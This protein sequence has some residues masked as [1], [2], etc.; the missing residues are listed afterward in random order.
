MTKNPETNLVSFKDTLNLPTTNFS[1]RSFAE[2]NDPIMITRWHDEK[3]SQQAQTINSGGEKFILHVGP[4]YAN[5]NIHL[6]HAYSW[7]LKD[8]VTKYHRMTGKHV[9][10]VP[11]WDCH[12]LPIEFQVSKEHPNASRIELKKEC[13]K[14]AQAW[15]N[16]Q[17]E[18]FER[19]GILMDWENPYITMDYAYEADTLRAFGQL[20]SKGYIK[21]KLKTVPWCISCETVLASAEIEYQDKK[22]PSLYVLFD[23]TKESARQLGAQC[24]DKQIS[25]VVWTTTPWTLPLN[26]AVLAKPDSEY[27][28]I[29]YND[30]LVIIGK[31][32]AESVCQLTDMDKRVVAE[33]NSIMLKDLRLHHPFEK[34]RIVPIIL[35][36]EVSTS[37]GTAFVHC[38]PGAGP[39]DYE[40]GIKNSIDIYSP[41][42]QSGNYTND[43]LPSELAGTPITDAHGFV[44]KTLTEH[45]KLFAKKSIAHSYPHCWRCHKPLIFRATK[46]WFCSLE[47]DKLKDRALDAIKKI[48]MIPE[49]TRNRF[50]STVQGRLEWCLSRQRVWG[51]PISALICNGCDYTHISKELV[52]QV[53]Q[54][55]Q[56]HGIEYWDSVAVTD[57]A[58]ADVHCPQCNAR[59]WRKEEDILDVWFDSGI[60]HYAVLKKREDQSYPA[61][62]YLEGKDQHRGWFQSSLLTSL[63][64][65]KDIPAMECILTHG[66]TVDQKGHKM[67]KSLG[68]VVSPDEMIKKL[69]TD[70]LRLWVSSIDYTNDAV[71][72]EAV[73]KNILIVYNKIRNT[74]RFL[75]ANLYDFN[76]ATDAVAVP[77]LL[78]IDQYALQELFEINTL[79]LD[80]YAQYDFTKVFH[81]LSDYCAVNLSAFYLD[82]IKDRLYVEKSDGLKRRSAQTACFYILDT[83]T[84]LMSPILS[85]TAEQVSDEYQK[86]KIESIH[87]QPFAE[88]PS[89]WQVQST[90]NKDM[91]TQFT[92]DNP[93][94]RSLHEMNKKMGEVQFLL[95]QQQSWDFIKQV[96]SEILKSIERQREKQVIKH[97]LEAKI[98]IYFDQSMQQAPVWNNF[99]TQCNDQNENIEEFL[100]EFIIVSQCKIASSNAANELE[101]TD[102]PGL[103]IKTEHADGSKCPRCWN[104]S[105][106]NHEHALCNRCEKIV[107]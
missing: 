88:I 34:N 51:T 38:A 63:V 50:S 40:I 84:R 13:R 71:V 16:R 39:V 73:V 58:G 12:G 87:L 44:I 5:G 33:F 77:E 52:E 65:D 67:S 85:F 22:D 53:A 81:V 76:I 61:D 24:A 57:L 23:V 79:L 80:A 96:R 49:S 36:N 104:W 10:V 29:E 17:M 15:V 20:V 2:I 54:Q 28:L 82:I 93:R 70:G 94:L 92:Q 103:Y 107:T 48:T 99:I 69:G 37:E 72:S 19:L 64:I 106:T 6:G 98:T 45:G 56:V 9:P 59:E 86:D 68:N 62:M 83:L 31:Q 42:S 55:V 102:I 46:Q 7:I 30:S 74:C 14:Y 1:I 90:K 32:L 8:M 35:D 26:R 21:R 91:Y 66:F 101:K 3:L 75:L 43:I 60:S 11:G 105:I 25:L 47:K 18:A 100:K 78:V 41:V 4:P 27:V 95:E 89:I 97:S